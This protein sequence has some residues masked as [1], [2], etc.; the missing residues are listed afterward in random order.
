MAATVKYDHAEWLTKHWSSECRPCG[1]FEYY[2]TERD[3]EAAAR[4][5]NQAHTWPTE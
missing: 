4:R 5:H 2:A 1:W 3:A